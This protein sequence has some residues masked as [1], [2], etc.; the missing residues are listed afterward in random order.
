MLP[1][2]GNILSLRSPNHSFSHQSVYFSLKY[3][4]NI[5]LSLGRCPES[6]SFSVC[7]CHRIGGTN[8]IIEVSQRWLAFLF[9]YVAMPAKDVYHDAIRNALINDQW[10]ITSDPFF[11]VYGKLRLVA[12]IGAEK[13]LE[14]QRGSEKIVVEVKSFLSRSFIYDLERA[15]GQYI[16][17]RNYLTRTHPEHQ[18]YLAMTNQVYTTYFDETIQIIVDDNQLKLIVVDVEKERITKWVK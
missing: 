13:I 10:H 11:I 4:S 9:A 3:T 17:Y 7:F 1:N 15:V 12:D 8:F 16:I 5:L 18:L 6:K 2:L 14:A